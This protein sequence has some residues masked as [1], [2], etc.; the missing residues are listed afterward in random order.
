MNRTFWSPYPHV[1]FCEAGRIN[2]EIVGQVLE[3][4]GDGH[5]D[6]GDRIARYRHPQ[7]DGEQQ[8][9]DLETKVVN[10]NP[11]EKTAPSKARH[12]QSSLPASCR[13]EN[14]ELGGSSSMKLSST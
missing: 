12:G 1:G 14:W 3:F 5:F 11:V 13:R 6:F 10:E 9:N 7:A 4:D 8:G 2:F